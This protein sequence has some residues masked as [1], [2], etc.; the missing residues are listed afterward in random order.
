MD[1]PITRT[2]LAGQAYSGKRVAIR[3]VR[4]AGSQG[5]R[6]KKRRDSP[7]ADSDGVVVRLS[8]RQRE[9]AKDTDNAGG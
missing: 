5:E 2:V 8:S 7:N 9:D 6:R 3:P 1:I 4:K